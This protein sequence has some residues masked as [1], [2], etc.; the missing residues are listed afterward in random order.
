MTTGRVFD[1]QRFSVHDGP[2]IRTTVFLKGCPLR[3]RW[4][5]NPEGL[6]RAISL[7]HFE[8]LCGRTGHC[9]DVCP[10]GAITLT[11]VGVE[12]NHAA[13]TLCGDCVEVCPNNA[14]AF[15]GRDIT[16]DEVLA[17]VSRDAIFHE[18]SGGGVTFSGG[19][20]LAQ[21]AF[22]R[23][24]AA[25]LKSRG[26]PTT[27]ESSFHAPWSSIE[28]LLPV[29]DLFIVDVKVADPAAHR[30][31]TGVS[32]ELILDNLRRLTK[33]LRGEG[34]ILVRVPLIPGYTATP[35]NLGAIADLLV[36]VDP[37]LPVE[38][39]N[40]NPL[41]SAKYRRMGM[42]YEFAD[43]ARAYSPAEMAGFQSLFAERGLT[44][45]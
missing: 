38:L 4:C 19:E 20:P 5:Q 22:V 3:C 25:A 28:P 15:D 27:L 30:V 42:A 26:L 40:F 2:G 37:S 39:M 1:I 16:T 13:C 21:P 17:E 44:V 9:Q 43:A 11:P 36:A 6:E 34:R 18:V 7:W 24:T 23:D 33:A 29:I 41:A 8:N 35:E 14:L 32:N 12:I 45:R 31:A 10:T